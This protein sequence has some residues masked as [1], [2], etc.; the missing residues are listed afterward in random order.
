MR[1]F[2]R[3]TVVI[4][5]I[6]GP[7]RIDQPLADDPGLTYVLPGQRFIYINPDGPWSLRIR[8]LGEIKDP[9]P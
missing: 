8:P 7:V 6:E 9:A 3:V 1:D 2:K 4:E 5:G